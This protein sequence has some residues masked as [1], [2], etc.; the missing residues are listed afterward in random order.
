MI[1][2]SLILTVAA[3][4][5]V[6]AVAGHLPSIGTWVAS[7]FRAGG[8]AVQTAVANV[9]HAVVH[10]LATAR[11]IEHAAVLKMIDDCGRVA[12]A[13]SDKSGIRSR[14]AELDAMEQSINKGLADLAAK[15]QAAVQQ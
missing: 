13:L 9:E 10:P 5:A 7:K 15:I 1:D 14:R 6:G 2:L 11:S 4:A 12:T 3:A 8:A